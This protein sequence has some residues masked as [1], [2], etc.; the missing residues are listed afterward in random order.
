M[1]KPLP[2]HDSAR[3]PGATYN[4]VTNP[5]T[6]PVGRLPMR[7]RRLHDG[8]GR[9]AQGE[10]CLGCTGG[11]IRR[12]WGEQSSSTHFPK[13]IAAP[14]RTVSRYPSHD[15]DLSAISAGVTGTYDVVGQAYLSKDHPTWPVLASSP[16]ARFLAKYRGTL[17]THIF[18]VSIN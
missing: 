13:E 2:Q 17:V 6:I 12:I 7:H 11:S 16:R 14:T 4:E 1:C 10:A 8:Q 18:R 5:A 3:C 9:Q 15:A